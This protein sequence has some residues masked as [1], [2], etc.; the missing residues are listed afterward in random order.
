MYEAGLVGATLAEGGLGGHVFGEGVSGGGA[1]PSF[2]AE[3]SLSSLSLRP[4]HRSG[5]GGA[6]CPG[7]SEPQ[8]RAEAWVWGLGR[9]GACPGRAAGSQGHW[10][11]DVT[12]R[13]GAQPL[14]KPDSS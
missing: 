13:L 7:P 6:G 5:G 2:E 10:S 12:V 8:G 14:P 1:S 9:A 3:G 11:M 4:L